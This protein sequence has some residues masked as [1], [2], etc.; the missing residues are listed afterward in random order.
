M[1]IIPYFRENISRIVK[2]NREF[3]LF[4]HDSYLLS[5]VRIQNSVMNLQA[6]LLQEM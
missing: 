3:P 2:N 5:M 6:I 4:V 1:V